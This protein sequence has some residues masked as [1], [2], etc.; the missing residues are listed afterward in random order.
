MA[1]NI[2]AVAIAAMDALPNPVLIKDRETRYVWVNSAFEEL[3]SVNRDEIE[4]ELDVDLFPDRQAAQCNGGDLRVLESGRIDEASET[5]F[6]PDLGPRQV[7]TRKSRVIV[8]GEAFLVGVLHDITEVTEQNRRLS[9]ATARLVDQAIELERLATTDSLTQ[10]LNRRVLLDSTSEFLDSDLTVGVVSIDLDSFKEI[11]DEFGHAAGDAILV[12]FAELARTEV[13]SGD[14]LARMG[15]EEFTVVL[16]EAS[17]AQT[18][19]VAERI[20]LLAEASPVAFEGRKIPYTV[21]VGAAFRAQAEEVSVEAL[22][23]LADDRLYAA[24]EAGRN[25]VRVAG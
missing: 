22:L 6:D 4:G 8:D 13:R 23:R 15:G 5:V 19:R 25:T 10:C 14:I 12:A 17:L 20:R 7:V 2:S 16:P 3:F 18:N 1:E 11:N 9:E 21:S 24:K